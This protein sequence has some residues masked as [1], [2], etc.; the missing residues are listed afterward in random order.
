[1]PQE[2]VHYITKAQVGQYMPVSRFHNR[3]LLKGMGPLIL[4]GHLIL[5]NQNH[6]PSHS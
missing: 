2:N 5:K 6:M 3:K 1:M 4:P